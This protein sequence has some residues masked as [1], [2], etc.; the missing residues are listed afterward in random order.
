MQ[1]NYIR[2]DLN[3]KKI[4]V[5]SPYGATKH[6]GEAIIQELRTRG[7]VVYGYDERPS[8]NS[9]VKIA[10]RLFKKR[11]PQIFTS[12]C[13]RIIRRH[14][15]I[16]LDY[17]LICR[18]EAFTPQSIMSLRSAFPES[19]VILYFWDILKCADLRN[20][21]PY[22]HK[23]YSFDPDDV[24]N[25]RGL[26]FR[27]TFFVPE[28]KSIRRDLSKEND[29]VFIGTL[30]S[31]RH[32]I[33]KRIK[34]ILKTQG[35]NLLTYLYIPSILVYI[36][37]CVYKFPYAKFKDVR[38]SPISIKDTIKLLERSKAILDIN[39]TAQKSL[40]TRAYEAMAGQIKYITTNPEVCQYDFYNPNNI[41]VVDINNLEIPRSFLDSPFEPV[42]ERILYKYS[43]SGLVDDLFS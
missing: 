21:I 27:P 18:G 39:Y 34:S 16:P 9:F 10:I 4:L 13:N 5:F 33:I 25:N 17:I 38:F 22:A 35:I 30:H 20:N 29:V 12:Y 8:Q 40:S 19:K 26:S 28:Y 32:K 37:D 31:N 43:V 7:A 15:D 14:K 36:K 42:S 11:I 2:V 41:L 24:A 6:Y 3:G 1:F 23:A